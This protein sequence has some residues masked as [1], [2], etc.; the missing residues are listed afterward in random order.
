[1][2]D[3][4][5]KLDRLLSSPDGMKRIEELMSAFG[6]SA[7]VPAEPTPPASLPTGM[8]IGILLKLTPLLA[9]LGKED[10]TTALFHAL[11]PHLQTDRQK[12]LDEAAQMLRLMKLLPL[13]GEL[14]GGE[15]AP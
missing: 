15:D 13:L 6:A 7:P 10:D 4:S 3:L 2:D 8:D 11:R 14:K 9:Q 5:E 1:M 12:K